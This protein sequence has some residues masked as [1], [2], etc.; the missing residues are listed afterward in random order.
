MSMPGFTA[1]NSLAPSSASYYGGRSLSFE[2]EEMVQPEFMG[3]IRE[4]FQSVGRSIS[5][6]LSS[7]GSS[8][9]NLINNSNNNN[10]PNQPPFICSQW[11]TTVV[12]CNNGSPAFSQNDMWTRCLM[13]NSTDPVNA[14]LCTGVSAALYPLVQKYC[15]EGDTDPGDLIGQICTDGN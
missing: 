6:G 8:L 7:L 4:A 1:A 2:A 11:I 13:S 3:V 5:P 14:A 15:S 9:G 12:A 10:G